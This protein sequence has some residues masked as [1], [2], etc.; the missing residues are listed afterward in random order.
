MNA[1]FVSTLSL[2][3][4]YS[5]DAP[6]YLIPKRTQPIQ[7]ILTHCGSFADIHMQI[8]TLVTM[9]TTTEKKSARGNFTRGQSMRKWTVFDGTCATQV[10]RGKKP[11]MHVKLG[12]VLTLVISFPY[13]NT[14]TWL[15]W[16][17]KGK[18]WFGL[19]CL[20]TPGLSKDNRCHVWS[21]FFSKLANHQIRHQIWHKNWA[22]ILVI[23]YGHFNLPQGFVWVRMS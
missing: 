6:V 19:C 15:T 3:T 4:V 9:A 21:Y 14:S 2:C 12:K 5:T 8:W 20:M 22:V 7:K 16:L 17:M 10:P 18:G 23:A 13:N 1:K 11:H